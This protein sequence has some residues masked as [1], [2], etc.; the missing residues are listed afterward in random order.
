MEEN[1]P[2]VQ[3]VPRPRTVPFSKA[4]QHR[5][6]SALPQR[7]S[8]QGVNFPSLLSHR[9][10]FPSEISWCTIEKVVVALRTMSQLSL[11][12]PTLP[13]HTQEQRS[14]L[15]AVIPPLEGEFLY[16]YDPARHPGLSIGDVLEVPLG[17]RKTRAFVT[18]INSAKESV[19]KAEMETRGVRIKDIPDDTAPSHAF[20]QEHLP[21]YEWVARYY[22]EPLSKV[23]DL[24]IPTPS[25]EKAIRAYVAGSGDQQTATSQVRAGSTQEKVLTFLKAQAAPVEQKHLL[26]VCGASPAILRSLVKKSLIEERK[27][28]AT[29]LVS[30]G[31]VITLPDLPLNDEQTRA[32]DAIRT[33]V[34]ERKFTT[35]LIQG[36]TGSGKTEVYLALII[37]ALRLGRSALVIV[38]EIALTPQLTERFTSRLKQ[39]VA[40]LHSGLKPKER[41]RHWTD[42]AAGRVKVAIGARSALFAPVNNLGV[43]VVD[44][45]HDSSFKQGDGIRYHARDLALVRGKLGSCPVILGSATPSLETYH[46][47]ITGKYLH[48]KLTQR[49]HTAANSRFT[50]VDLNAVK[51]WEMKTKS[52]APQFFSS[53]HQALSQG[54][55]AFVLYNKRGFASYLQCS[56]CE[57]VLGCPHCSVTLTFHRHSNSLLCHQCNFSMVPPIVCST[58]GA[59]ES[60]EGTGD[61]LFTQRGSGTERVHEEISSLFPK[62]RVAT[63][64]RDSAST[65]ADYVDI[66]GR[67][68]NREIDILVG[69]QMIAKGHDLPGVTFV[70]IVDCDVGLHLPDFRAAERSF[71]LLTQVAGRAGRRQEQGHV[72]LQTRVPSHQSLAMT[73][74]SNYFD[75]AQHE[76]D[77]RHRLGYPPF[78]KLLRIIISCA[79]R[80]RA[81]QD[82]AAVAK[83]ARQLL[84]GKDIELLGPAP[85]PIEKIRTLWRYHVLLKAA[86]AAELQH[87]M[88]HIKQLH[89]SSAEVRIAYDLDP[90]E[91]L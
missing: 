41:W 52:I 84:A 37:E 86:S 54:G 80:S 79:D 68:R 32:V 49:Y 46:H 74:A 1:Y 44:E 34:L 14:F 36:V 40:V 51:P 31:A 4:P 66:L 72:V 47:A 7:V 11:E 39:H 55:Q 59:H 62:A 88:K 23:L 58:C 30:A 29:N 21:F 33:H 28:S 42:L 85:A 50:I 87:L 63:L 43:L 67:V 65:I 8:F 89:P 35:A 20:N 61:P 71:Q 45:E 3:S 69:T 77:L 10:H 60:I 15:S 73:A 57:N 27:I 75:F 22:A 38:P 78:R 2:I 90:H 83:T 24:A 9:L 12:L 56:K 91:M 64:D 26:E 19:S 81:L 25:P 70:G 6:R 16:G 17:R 5:T 76:L 48:L 53:L 18:S 82:S 13:P